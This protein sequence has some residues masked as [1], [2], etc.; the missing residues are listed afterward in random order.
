MRWICMTC[1]NCL[2]LLLDA[3]RC[4]DVALGPLKQIPMN[5]FIMYMSGNTISIFPIMMVCM[6]A[7]R[8]IQALMSMS[9]SE[10]PLVTFT[11]FS[12]FK[13]LQSSCT[14][15]FHLFVLVCSS[16]QA[17]RELQSAVAAGTRLPDREPSGSS[18]GHLQV[19]VD[20]ATSNTLV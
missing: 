16:L 2:P 1:K 5:L 17:V 13:L 14:E 7:W 9:A 15:S 20:G 6:M 11:F 19:S 8:P 3:Q 4:W 18:V 12:S 10:C